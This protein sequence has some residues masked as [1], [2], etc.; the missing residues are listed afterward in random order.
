MKKTIKNRPLVTIT[1]SLLYDFFKY[2]RS[3]G[4]LVQFVR[5]AI[6]A[7]E[8]RLETLVKYK[9]PESWIFG[10]FVWEETPEGHEAW[11]K[12]ADG[13]KDLLEKAAD[14]ALQEAGIDAEI[15]FKGEA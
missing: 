1:V 8:Q 11:A 2:L 10:A 14:S 13:W 7:D 3:R 6:M 4:V 5:A 15:V 12:V 9:A